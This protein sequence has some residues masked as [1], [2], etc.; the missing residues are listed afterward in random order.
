MTPED[1]HLLANQS[2]PTM[3]T[4]PI[5]SPSSDLVVIQSTAPQQ[6]GTHGAWLFCPGSDGALY[7]CQHLRSTERGSRS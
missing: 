7:G 2:T 4:I 6:D 5:L 3:L 1:V